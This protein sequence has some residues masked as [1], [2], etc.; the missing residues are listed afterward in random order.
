VQEA[1]I[2]VTVKVEDVPP[3]SCTVAVSV[4]VFTLAV[5]GITKVTLPF[6]V[7]LVG[8]ALSPLAVQAQVALVVV[9]LTLATPPAAVA[10]TLAGVMESAQLEPNWVM[11][12]DC[13]C[14]AIEPMRAAPA[15]FAVRLYCTLAD[16][17]PEAK[18]GSMVTKLLVVVAVHGQSEPVDTVKLP[19]PPAAVMVPA[20]GIRV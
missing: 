6:P 16:P 19:D 11:V 15:A 17:V 7:P 13:P 9:T 18:A 4:W 5:D 8:E 1:P 10:V 2:W 12:Y 3:L 14:T 20:L